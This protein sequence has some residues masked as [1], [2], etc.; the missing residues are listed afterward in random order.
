M[1]YFKYLQYMHKFLLLQFC[2]LMHTYINK[3]DNSKH[4]KIMLNITRIKVFNSLGILAKNVL[5]LN[6]FR[7]KHFNVSVTHTCTSKRF[8]E[9]NRRIDKN[10]LDKNK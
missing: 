4:N 8:T 3:Q 2:N 1:K 7:S 9:I 6:Q 10:K 5:L